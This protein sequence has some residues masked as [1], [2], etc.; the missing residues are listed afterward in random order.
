M[1]I[2]FPISLG[3]ILILCIILGSPIVYL[4]IK[5]GEVIDVIAGYTSEIAIGSFA[6]FFI[7]AIIYYIIT[8]DL[9]SAIPIA[10]NTPAIG[11]FSAFAI[12]ELARGFGIIYG[13]ISIILSTIGWIA[14][15]MVT[16]GVFFLL[17]DLADNAEKAKNKTSHASVVAK[18]FIYSIIG[19][20]LQ[21]G[22]FA[23]CFF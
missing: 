11:I 4:G 13:I 7:I 20:L 10:L 21:F 14:T 3:T 17:I 1:V 2:L 19:V 6:L 18:S 16:G 23:F 22:I 9:S 15:I 12:A 5:I 8:K